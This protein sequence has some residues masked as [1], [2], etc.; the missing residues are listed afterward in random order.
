[1]HAETVTEMKMPNNYVDMESDEIEY[2]GG[3]SDAARL[4]TIIGI[5]VG[6]V[7]GITLTT[8]LLLRSGAA[9]TV[10]EGAMTNS[11]EFSVIT[12]GPLTIKVPLE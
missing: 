5:S 11:G 9:A 12:K 3:M 2:D 8:A 6:A 7:I 1:M 10:A 4:W